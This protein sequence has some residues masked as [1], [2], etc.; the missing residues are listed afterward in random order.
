MKVYISLP[1]TGLDIKEVKA[2]ADEVKKKLK[3][4]GHIPVSPLD[5]TPDKEMPYSYYMGADIMALIESEAVMFLHGWQKSKGCMLEFHAA[6]IYKK[7]IIFQDG[8]LHSTNRQP[9]PE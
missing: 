3:E 9:V 6:N 8:K 2:R 1:I 4:M 5:I 7:E